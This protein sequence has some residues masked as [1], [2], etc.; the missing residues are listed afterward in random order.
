MEQIIVDIL[1]QALVIWLAYRWGCRVA[2]LRL[3][4]KLLEGDPELM[5]AIEQAQRLGR[6]LARA[7]SADQQDIWVEQVNSYYYIYARNQG[8]LGQGPDLATALAQ[9]QTRQ[10]GLTATVDQLA[11]LIKTSESKHLT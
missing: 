1:V 5:R 11:K 9:A 7:Q 8:F 4:Q 3:T 10:P 2:A 6:D